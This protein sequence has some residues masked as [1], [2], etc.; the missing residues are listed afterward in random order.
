MEI[1]LK[2]L[3]RHVKAPLLVAVLRGHGWGAGCP[4]ITKISIGHCGI[5]RIFINWSKVKT[6]VEVLK[7][8]MCSRGVTIN[9]LETSQWL[10]NDTTIDTYF[11][12]F[13]LLV[14]D[15][16]PKE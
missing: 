9:C 4:F 12:I 7:A 6:T 5:P 8:T 3:K 10:P 15:I 1:F 2:H 13:S 11:N 14:R 16:S